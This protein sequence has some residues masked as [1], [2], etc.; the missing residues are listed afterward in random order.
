M[1]P[2]PPTDAE[3]TADLPPS[4]EAIAT[5]LSQSLLQITREAARVRPE[6]W[7]TLFRQLETALREMVAHPFIR[8]D[9]EAEARLD[10]VLRAQDLEQ[11]NAQVD[12]FADY[13][14]GKLAFNASLKGEGDAAMPHRPTVSQDSSSVTTRAQAAGGP[15]GSDFDIRPPET[16]VNATAS[17]GKDA[18]AAPIRRSVLRL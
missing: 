15:S 13:V 2:A 5:E 1:P 4:A 16:A 14:I 10:R 17:D 18:A 12:H 7:A 9:L 6:D 8:G 11:M 3:P